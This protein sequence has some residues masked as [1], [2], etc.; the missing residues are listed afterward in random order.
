LRLVPR[1]GLSLLFARGLRTKTTVALSRAE[2]RELAELLTTTELGSIL[3]LL[4][5][6][7]LWALGE[8]H[9]AS[10]DL[11][12]ASCQSDPGTF[13]PRAGYDHEEVR[14]IRQ[15]KAVLLQGFERRERRDSN[16]RP[17]A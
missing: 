5:E 6:A 1:R 8:S 15:S 10:W 12:F 17:P 7:L 2:A 13:G 11:L 14:A 9:G 4:R 16:P 3:T